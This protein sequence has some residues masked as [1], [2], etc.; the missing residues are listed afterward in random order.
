MAGKIILSLKKSLSTLYMKALAYVRSEN[1]EIGSNGAMFSPHNI[2]CFRFT[3]IEVTP[4]K[5]G[6]FTDYQS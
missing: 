1:I 5:A 6:P 2:P 3:E 4:D